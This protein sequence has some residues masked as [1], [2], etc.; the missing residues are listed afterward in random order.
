MDA[1]RQKL[2]KSALANLDAISF[3]AENFT[4]QNFV[5]FPKMCG[6]Y[7][8]DLSGSQVTAWIYS[9]ER[10]KKSSDAVSKFSACK[11]VKKF[12]AQFHDTCVQTRSCLLLSSDAFW[13]ISLCEVYEES[14]GRIFTIYA[15]KTEAVKF[16]CILEVFALQASY[17]KLW[18]H[19][20]DLCLKTKLFALKFRRI[21]EVFCPQASQKMLWAQFHGLCVQNRSC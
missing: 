9:R 3:T 13:K 17:K 18:A 8:H 7:I 20:H 4:K 21:L 15:S 14:S 6:A 16:R 5:T 12:W 1:N 10:W 11:F 2:W 19:F